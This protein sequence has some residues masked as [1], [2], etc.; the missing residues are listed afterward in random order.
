M[1]WSGISFAA[2]TFG[3]LFLW[4]SCHRKMSFV[5]QTACNFPIWAHCVLNFLLASS[6]SADKLLFLFVAVSTQEHIGNALLATEVCSK[7][8]WLIFSGLKL[9]MW[10]C[11]LVWTVTASNQPS[12]FCFQDWDKTGQRNCGCHHWQDQQSSFQGIGAL[13]QLITTSTSKL[14]Y[15]SGVYGLHYSTLIHVNCLTIIGWQL[16]EV[17]NHTSHEDHSN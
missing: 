17:A 6:H 1:V 4:K 2:A 13:S 7:I 15:T 16:N 3:V 11:N 8:F 12:G 9:L 10:L 14:H 5:P